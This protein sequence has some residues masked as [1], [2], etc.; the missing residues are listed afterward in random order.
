MSARAAR[1]LSTLIGISGSSSSRGNNQSAN[2]RAPNSNAAQTGKLLTSSS[3][4]N[5][6]IPVATNAIA[7]ATTPKNGTITANK[8]RTKPQT[9]DPLRPKVLKYLS[10]ATTNRR[11]RV[12]NTAAN[13][14]SSKITGAVSRRVFNAVA[15]LNKRRSAVRPLT[16]LDKSVS[17]TPQFPGLT[18]DGPRESN[19]SAWRARMI[20]SISPIRPSARL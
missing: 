20:V 14:S 16:A 18:G 17:A 13:P 7:K 1:R 9:S 10:R 15:S 12:N 11:P 6:S 19:L 2:Q 8:E 5:P 3:P 4:R